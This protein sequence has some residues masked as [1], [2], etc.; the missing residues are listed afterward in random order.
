MAAQ[1]YI[2]QACPPESLSVPM[3]QKG[4]PETERG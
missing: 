3:N 4:S 1:D 2:A